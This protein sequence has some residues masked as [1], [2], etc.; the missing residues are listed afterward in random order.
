MKNRLSAQSPERV[1]ISPLGDQ[2]LSLCL[3]DCI[4][5]EVSIRVRRALSRF[6]A[7]NIEGITDLQPTYTGI[8]VVYDPMVIRYGELSERLHKLLESPGMY[9]EEKIGRLVEIPVCYGGKYG[10]D[11][12]SVAAHHRMSAEEVIAIH[13]SRQYTIAMLG[14]LPGFPYLRGLSSRLFTPRLSSP[15]V[16]IPAGSVGIGGEQTGVYPVESPGG[17]RLIGRTPLLLFDPRRKEAIPYRAGDRIR[18]RPITEAEYEA[19]RKEQVQV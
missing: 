15:R 3:G 19:L 13:A 5:E 10:P 18:F 16:R 2:V 12:E 9:A 1:M 11:L 4:S 17:W 6:E 7:E 14:F 8:T